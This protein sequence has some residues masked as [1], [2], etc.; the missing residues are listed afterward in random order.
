LARAEQDPAR[1]ADFWETIHQAE[2]LDE[3]ATAW[4]I[5]RHRSSGNT[6]GL[7]MLLQRRRDAKAEMEAL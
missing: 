3:E 4:L 1:A 2:P 7:R 6:G 5:E